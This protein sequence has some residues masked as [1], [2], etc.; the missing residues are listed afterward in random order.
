MHGINHCRS[1]P[2]TRGGG[3]CFAVHSSVTP[4]VI[5]EQNRLLAEILTRRRLPYAANLADVVFNRFFAPAERIGNSSNKS[6]RSLL[7]SSG[8]SQLDRCHQAVCTCLTRRVIAP[9]ISSVRVPEVHRSN[10]A[11]ISFAVGFGYLQGGATNNHIHII[12]DIAP[13]LL[14]EPGVPSRAFST[15]LSI[16]A[17][18][19]YRSRLRLSLKINV[20]SLSWFRSFWGPPRASFG[21]C[22]TMAIKD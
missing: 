9:P 11:T 10:N 17:Q 15:C 7:A 5:R 20:Y 16:S 1:V 18:T 3:R 4:G 8:P 21:R 13:F 14:G 22:N 2:A 19:T 6:S 12:P